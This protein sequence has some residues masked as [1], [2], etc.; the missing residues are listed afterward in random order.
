[1]QNNIYGYIRVSTTAQN[2][3]RQWIAM[4]KFGI[5][6]ECVFAD[7]QSGK[8][9]DRPAYHDLMGR[10]KQGDTLVVKS[11]DRLGRNYDEMI[12]QLDII[13]RLCITFDGNSFK[14]IFRYYKMPRGFMS[15]SSGHFFICQR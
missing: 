6:R 10:L 7:K 8:D 1:M 4:D 11:L 12:E 9:F 2:D 15:K 5:P 14:E 3:E 13:M